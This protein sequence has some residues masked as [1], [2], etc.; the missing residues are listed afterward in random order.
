MIRILS[1]VLIAILILCGCSVKK[2]NH[3]QVVCTTS[4]ITDVV[5]IIAGEEL[6]V[7]G[8]MGPGVDPHLYKASA[9]D[10]RLLDNAEIV[11]YNGLDLEAKMHEFLVQL[12][13]KKTVVALGETLDKQVLIK[14]DEQLYDPHIWFDLDLFSTVILEIKNQLQKKY[15]KFKNTFDKNYTELKKRFE[16]LA[17]SNNN[18]ISSLSKHQRILITAHDAFGYFGRAYDFEV[19]GLQGVSTQS[20][21][22]LADVSKLAQLIVSKKVPAI[23]VESSI[24]PRQIKAVQEAVKAQGFHVEIGGQL[25]SDALGQEGSPE[26]TYLG[27]FEHNINTIVTALSTDKKNL[28][29]IGSQH[30]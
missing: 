14:V 20:E 22:G 24:S 17:L 30:D 8:L 3:A 15:P 7:A 10:V 1:S 4:M 18:A 5:S 19:I 25:F 21:A 27:M 12:S 9:K 16:K 11:F 2:D 13:S 23:F 6:T 29:G 26:A 28:N